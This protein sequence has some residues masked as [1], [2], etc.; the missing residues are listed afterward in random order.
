MKPLHII[1]IFILLFASCAMSGCSD[2]ERM[3]TFNEI[4]N[5]IGNDPK[6]AV[7]YVDSL[8]ADI[9]WKEGMNAAER[10]R[11][12]LLRVKSADKAYV[13]HTSDSLIRTVLEYYE[14][15]PGSKQYPEALYY[16]GR[17]YSDLGDSPTAL[18]YFQHALDALPT[19]GNEELMAKVLSQTARL[20]N[21]MRMYDEALKY[22]D[23]A[24]RIESQLNDTSNLAYDYE[25]SGALFMHADSLNQAK[26]R[27]GKALAL[28]K[29]GTALQARQ[30]TY[31]AAAEYK[32]GNIGEAVRLISGMPDRITGTYRTTSMGYAAIIYLEARQYDSARYYA[33][34]ILDEKDP[35]NRRIA[36]SILLSPH[37]KEMLLPDS[38]E[39]YY[40]RYGEEVSEFAENNNREACAFSNAI[41]NYGIHDR[42]RQQAEDDKKT[43]AIAGL[44]LLLAVLGLCLAVAVIRQ[45]NN[46]NKLDLYEA[47]ENIRTLRSLLVSA[48]SEKEAQDNGMETECKPVTDN[49][50]NQNEDATPDNTT[51]SEFLSDDEKSCLEVT[52]VCADVET[53]DERL[54][55]ILRKELLGL[56][57]VSSKYTR[58][59]KNYI[60]PERIAKS[61]AYKDVCR[62]LETGKALP[63]DATIWQDLKKLAGEVWPG[64]QDKL[65]MLAGA[66]IKEKDYRLCLLIK[67]G[68]SP[69]DITILSG[70]TKGTISSRRARL[71]K[72]IL[73]ENAGANG[74][75]IVILSL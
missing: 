24:I 41:Y 40:V 15:H 63:P 48:H 50:E 59:S 53:E 70:R 66:R 73:G 46:R 49:D 38:V 31:L 54:R 20:M 27:F 13:R 23:E 51:G 75:D 2:S 71:C 8:N 9:G 61:E 39:N 56:I 33:E 4:E 57:T 18:R 29:T 1:Y 30:Y 26:E 19:K 10:A 25:L 43:Y 72:E 42:R 55:L 74:F 14:K 34:R 11:F 68:F 16:G 52:S 58:P 5:R 64:L 62:S 17:V 69:T 32:S 47:L 35:R 21:R 7:R 6:V 44:C 37:V 65:N 36:Y 22:L 28:C 60:V 12:D 67:L 45:R 3:N